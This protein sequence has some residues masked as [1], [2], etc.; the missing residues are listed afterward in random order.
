M[1][2]ALVVL[3]LLSLRAQTGGWGTTLIDAD[4][5]WLDLP[6]TAAWLERHRRVLNLREART[7]LL[8]PRGFLTGASSARLLSLHRT[9]EGLEWRWEV[10]GDTFLLR[11]RKVPI[12]RLRKHLVLL[13]GPCAKGPQQIEVMT[14]FRSRS[15]DLSSQ[16]EQ[17]GWQPFLPAAWEEEIL[18]PLA[19]P[20]RYSPAAITAMSFLLE[21]KEGEKS[22]YLRE[23]RLYGRKSA[24]LPRD[25]ILASWGRRRLSGKF[26]WRLRGIW[27]AHPPY[28]YV[29][30]VNDYYPASIAEG[31]V[32]VG[33]IETG[34]CVRPGEILEG[35]EQRLRP[36]W[37]ARL[38]DQKTPTL[39][40]WELR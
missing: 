30:R 33:L 2:S 4:T 32:W 22:F 3:S 11:S 5:V 23:V 27:Q 13:R 37:E 28:G 8:C 35:E 17:W 29:I 21:R 14:V 12:Q 36:V 25:E 1:R 31:V 26:L 20:Y 7:G 18:A 34:K 38:K 9:A 16:E 15:R 10:G 40:L 39:P 6:K 19:L 24:F